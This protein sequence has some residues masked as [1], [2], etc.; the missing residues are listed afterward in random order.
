M[1]AVWWWVR[2][3]PTHEKAFVGHRDV[4]ADL[5]DSAAIARLAAYLPAD[6]LLVS[7]DLS[8]S[9]TTADAISMGRPRLPHSPALREF[10]FGVWDGMTFDAVSARDPALSRAY[11]ETP[12]DITP[13]HGESW[14]TA[15]ARIAPFVDALNM[16]H[17]GRHIIAVAHFGV[18]LTQI[19]RATGQT[20]V[21]AIGQK[22][23]TLSVSR[24]IYGA[25]ALAD[26][27]NH[28]P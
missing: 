11:W 23:D 7:S 20:P 5:S 24:V 22:I 14:N 25:K 21:E 15:S 16:A 17:P 2:H 19:A 9:I 28:I 27:I 26:P 18:I 10:D 12:G 3:G 6:A 1:S 13:P 8:R 4:P